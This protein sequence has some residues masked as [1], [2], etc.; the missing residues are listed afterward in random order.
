MADISPLQGI[1][2]DVLSR[3]THL[4]EVAPMVRWINNDRQA[5]SSHNFW[6]GESEAIAVAIYYYLDAEA[7]EAPT[8][9]IYSGERLINEL[10][11][12]NEAGINRVEWDGTVRRERTEEE[13]RQYEEMMERRRQ[14]GGGF[15]RFGRP[16][17][18]DYV[19]SPAP[20]GD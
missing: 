6:T 10:E 18:P 16:M 19:F 13:R 9:S 15:G 12:S 1:S 5:V 20:V 7:A 11:G 2:P 4:F 3:G 8:I 17:D 14:M